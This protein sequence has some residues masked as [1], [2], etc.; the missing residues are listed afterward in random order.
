MYRAKTWDFGLPSHIPHRYLSLGLAIATTAYDHLSPFPQVQAD[1]AT[2]AGLCVLFDDGAS[3]IGIPPMQEFP[4]RFY[5]NQPHLHPVL[6]RFADIIRSIGKHFSPFC[7]NAIVVSTMDFVS[8]ELFMKDAAD[9]PLVLG[10]SK[11]IK[12]MRTKDGID[13][14]FAALMFLLCMFPDP[15]AY[16]Q[17]F[18]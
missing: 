8:A 17:A 3:I 7:A 13:E 10:S 18:P 4:R 14:A 1:L 6:D 9:M 11:Y 5:T 16:I 12:Y 2:Y 15:T